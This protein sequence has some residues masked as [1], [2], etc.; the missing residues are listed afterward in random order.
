MSCHKVFVILLGEGQTHGV[1][2]SGP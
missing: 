2:S 1:W